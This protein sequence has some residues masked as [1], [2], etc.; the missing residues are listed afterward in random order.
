MG[1]AGLDAVACI[2]AER[3]GDGARW[4][5][6]T[7]MGEAGTFR[8][9]CLHEL[10]FYFR[11]LLHVPAV[12]GQKHCPTNPITWLI[13]VFN[14]RGLA[15]QHTGGDGEILAHNW[16]RAFLAREG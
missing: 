3:Q 15:P 2:V 1:K 12:S 13:A 5:N 7:V 10:R 4:R 11:Q 6:R 14:Q 9:Q 8:C 16:S